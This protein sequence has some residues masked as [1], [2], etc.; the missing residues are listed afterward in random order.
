MAEESRVFL[1]A[2]TSP[3]V[4][5]SGQVQDEAVH[6]RPERGAAEFNAEQMVCGGQGNCQCKLGKV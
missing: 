1:L 3:I 2:I 4:G 5:E 6:V